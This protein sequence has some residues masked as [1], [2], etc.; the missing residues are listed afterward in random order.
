MD[1]KETNAGVRY[2]RKDIRLRV[3]LALIVGAFCLTAALYYATWRLFWWREGFQGTSTES[4]Y[5][6]A[7]RLTERLP[8]EPR[9]EQ[10]DLLTGAEN[11]RLSKGLAAQQ[12]ALHSYGSTTEKGFVQIPIEQ[13]IKAVAGKLPARKARETSP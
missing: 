9:L 13:A 11:A 10:V 1:N 5:A 12:Q 4:P 7:A 6:A 3:L 8:R 2:E